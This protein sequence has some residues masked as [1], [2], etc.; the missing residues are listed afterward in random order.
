MSCIASSLTRTHAHLGPIP[1]ILIHHCSSH[2]FSLDVTQPLSHVLVMV[3]KG[4]GLLRGMYWRWRRHSGLGKWIG[5]R[6]HLISAS[7]SRRR[8]GAVGIMGNIWSNNVWRLTLGRWTWSSNRCR[9]RG[10]VGVV[11]IT[12]DKVDGLL[13]WT[14]KLHTRR[15]ASAYRFRMMRR[16][17]SIFTKDILQSVRLSNNRAASMNQSLIIIGG[18]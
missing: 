6:W 16:T 10:R 5:S 1:L 17:D 15:S 7:E 11:C 18:S 9:R 12:Y 3:L 8:L 4:R 2:S 14:S 13:I